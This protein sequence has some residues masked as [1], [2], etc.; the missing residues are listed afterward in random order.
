[1]RRFRSPRTR[2]CSTRSSRASTPSRRASL[3]GQIDEAAA[4]LAMA[5]HELDQRAGAVPPARSRVRRSRAVHGYVA[6]DPAARRAVT[7]GTEVLRLTGIENVEV[8]A[9]ADR[10]GR[11]RPSARR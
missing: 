1:M 4:R 6:G 7:A 2:I 5:R 8:V 3:Q 9:R 10:G 11:H